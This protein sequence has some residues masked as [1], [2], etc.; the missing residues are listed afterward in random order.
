MISINH[1]LNKNLAKTKG[2]EF[3]YNMWIARTAFCTDSSQIN[4]F[5]INSSYILQMD[6]QPSPVNE[7]I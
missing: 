1:I 5:I 2:S 7:K 6:F 4:L 3:Y